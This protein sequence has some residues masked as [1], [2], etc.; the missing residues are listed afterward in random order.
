MCLIQNQKLNW[1]KNITFLTLLFIA[2]L[3]YNAQSQSD[4]RFGFQISPNLTWINSNDNTINREGT[5]IGL[6]LGVMGEYY[7]TERYAITG[8]LG[9][10]FGQGGSLIHETGG[11]FFRESEISNPTLNS[12]DKPLPDGVELGYNIQYV[13][14]PFG[15]KLRTDEIGYLRYFAEIPVFTLSFRAQ[16]R[17]S[18]MGGEINEEDLDI[19]RDVTPINFS[20]G[21]GGGIEYSITSNAVLIAGI[22]YNSSFIDITDND[23]IQ[24]LEFIDAGVDVNDPA[25]DNF[26]T[27]PE[28]SNVSIGSITLRIGVLF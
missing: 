19:N 14:I 10:A 15:L 26:V 7:F 4:I 13:E 9:F 25:D 2:G 18:I 22:Y 8:G 11:N 21:V 16:S 17:G 3:C 27:R 1:M 6:R 28:D 24:A 12:G 5:N 23:A 20:W